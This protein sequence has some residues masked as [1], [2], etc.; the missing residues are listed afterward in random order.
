MV[1]IGQA[2]ERNTLRDSTHIK[3]GSLMRIRSDE[4]IM[5]SGLEPDAT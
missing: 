5:A 4:T 1:L 3:R 2:R